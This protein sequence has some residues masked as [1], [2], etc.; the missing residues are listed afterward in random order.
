M[1]LP[2]LHPNSCVESLTCNVNVQWRLEPLKRQLRQKGGHKC[3]AIIQYAGLIRGRDIK[4]C[5][6]TEERPCEVTGR[7]Q[8]SGEGERIRRN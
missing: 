4:G 7:G 2:Q 6:C 8:L 1:S 3:G 5:V